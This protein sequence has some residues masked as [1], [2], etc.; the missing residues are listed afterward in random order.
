MDIRTDLRSVHLHVFRSREHACRVTQVT[1][2]LGTT[3]QTVGP[4]VEELVASG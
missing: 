3:K 1:A 2:R 4:M